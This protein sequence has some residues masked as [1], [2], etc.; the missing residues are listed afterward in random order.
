VCGADHAGRGSGAGPNPA[1]S[2][3]EVAGSSGVDDRPGRPLLRG[4]DLVALGITPGRHFGPVMRAALAAQDDG[5][6]ADR[7]GAVDWLARVQADGR[8]GRLL[9]SRPSGT[10]PG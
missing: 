4:S 1:T 3:L 5:E 6:F 7:A 2:W 10:G 9:T 8:L